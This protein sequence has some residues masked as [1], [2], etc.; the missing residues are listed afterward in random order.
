MISEDLVKQVVANVLRRVDAEPSAAVPSPPN[1]PQGV[2]PPATS[3]QDRGLSLEAEEWPAPAEFFA[4]W[5]GE[6]FKAAD[7]PAAYPPQPRSPAAHP[8]QEQFSINEAAEIKSAISE[9]V[10]FF[11]TQRCTLEKNKPCDH[12]G[13]C[14]ALGF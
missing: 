11:E 5:T 9:L 8:S 12:C 14:R 13:A 3:D 2:A 6:V 4:P 7:S 10:E 1:Q